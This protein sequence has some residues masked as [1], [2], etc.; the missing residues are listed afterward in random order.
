MKKTMRKASLM[1][2]MAFATASASAQQYVTEAP[3]AGFD[4]KQG[5]DYV[6]LYAPEAQINAIGDRMKSN[7]NLDPTRE[8]NQFFYWTAEWDSKLFT[9]WDMEDNSAN[10]WGGEDKLNMTPLFAWGGGHFGANSQQYDLSAI[11]DDHILHIGF[12]N[13][14]AE[15]ATAYFQF[16]LGP[17]AKGGNGFALEINREIG[18]FAD[19]FV[20]IG[21]APVRDK[22]YYLDIPVKDLIDV[23]DNGQFGFEYDFSQPME[24]P[25]TC[26][27]ESATVTTYDETKTGDNGVVDPETG[28]Y[29]IDVL[30]TGSAMAIDGVFLY[31][32]SSDGISNLKAD[33]KDNVKAVYDLQGRRATANK[34]G[35]YIVKTADGVKK[36]AVK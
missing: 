1:A 29:V 25:F 24:I 17:D 33:K 11:T 35:I 22:W 28:M 15:D 4:F 27:F 9:L 32:K 5:T 18:F 26:G 14:G 13:I 19:P 16:S 6:V 8:K 2:V 36:V 23:S 12:K 20:G 34:A 30:Q 7:Q 31:K 21:L 3:A 10:S